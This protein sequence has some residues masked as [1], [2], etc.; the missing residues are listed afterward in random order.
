MRRLL[1][2]IEK[3]L[4]RLLEP[5]VFEPNN[6]LL[7]HCAV[8]TV[9][10]FLGRLH[11]A[12]MLAGDNPR[13]A[14]AVRCDE[15]VNPPASQAA[16]RLVIEVAVAPTVPYEFLTFRIGHAFDALRITEEG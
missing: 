8:T 5:V 10:A 6:E 4:Q 9:E 7:W 15:Q 12:G 2:A 13:A 14:Y 3:S 1:D 11:R 16:G